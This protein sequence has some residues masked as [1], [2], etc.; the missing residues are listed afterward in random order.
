M[1]LI[2]V[3][4][5]LIINFSSGFLYDYIGI[6]GLSFANS[7]HRDELF[8]FIASLKRDDFKIQFLNANSI[9]SWRHVASAAMKTLRSFK[10]GRNVSNKLEIELLLY[11]SGMRQIKDALKIVG[12]D[13]FINKAILVIFGFNKSSIHEGLKSVISTFNVKLDYNLLLDLSDDK[14]KHI[15]KVF[16]ISDN[17][18]MSISKPN[19]SISEILELIVIE[20]SSLFEIS[21]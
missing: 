11:C 6:F 19:L 8:Y 10:Y 18:L 5:G 1:E 20:R 13:E 4:G 3:D 12:L 16:N 2:N 15:I 9:I 21:K 14:I 17:E 7:I